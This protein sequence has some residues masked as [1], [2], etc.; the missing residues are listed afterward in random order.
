MVAVSTTDVTPCVT[1]ASLTR[2]GVG[3]FVVVIPDV[4]GST[5]TGVS[6]GTIVGTGDNVGG[7]PPN[8]V[9][10]VYWPHREAFPTQETSRQAETKT[11]I[12]TRFTVRIIPLLKAS[13]AG[14]G[15]FLF[16]K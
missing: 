3:V 6:V 13:L 12:R 7:T 8:G 5:G 4:I 2:V 11:G 14:C 10:V 16:G 9:G 1:N 15:S